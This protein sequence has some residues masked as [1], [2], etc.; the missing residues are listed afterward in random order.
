MNLRV[1]EVLEANWG[2]Q[3]LRQ[4]DV[5]AVLG[6]RF[7]RIRR[8]L[9][10][11]ADDYEEVRLGTLRRYAEHEKDEDDEVVK[12]REGKPVIAT[13]EEGQALFPDEDAE[14]DYRDEIQQARNQTVEVQHA[15]ISEEALK[16]LGDVP[17]VILDAISPLVE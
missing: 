9:A 10:D 2:L 4:Y 13:D 1:E 11:Y 5:P 8:E 7:A 15:P 3:Q 12:D 17:F 6:I 14:Q 16:N